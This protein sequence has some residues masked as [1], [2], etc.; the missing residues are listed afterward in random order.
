[1]NNT[2]TH[3]ATKN[4]RVTAN[5]LLTFVI[6]RAMSE[7]RVEVRRRN[8]EQVARRGF[9]AVPPAMITGESVADKALPNA[10]IDSMI[11]PM[12]FCSGP[13]HTQVKRLASI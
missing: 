3:A 7:S 5:D 8:V 6:D 9:E 11:H 4:P 12:P 1:M 2:P 10:G 13:Q